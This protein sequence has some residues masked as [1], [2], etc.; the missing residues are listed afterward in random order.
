MGPTCQVHAVGSLGQLFS[1]EPPH[2]LSGECQ[3]QV[4]APFLRRPAGA[5]V[6][7]PHCTAQEAPA[8]SLTPALPSRPWGEPPVPT[9][10]CHWPGGSAQAG[11]SQPAFRRKMEREVVEL[12]KAARLPSHTAQRDWCWLGLCHPGMSLSEAPGFC[13]LRTAVPCLPAGDP[14]L[15]AAQL[16]E[17]SPVPSE[18]LAQ[19]SPGT[20]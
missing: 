17:A 5:P 14:F 4:K 18:D 11:T 20:R 13:D 7:S 3:C 1:A 16:P 10:P 15:L 19:T 8:G 2:G 12:H 6:G 9:E